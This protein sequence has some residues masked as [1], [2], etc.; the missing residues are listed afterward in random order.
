MLN[1]ITSLLQRYRSI[2][3]ST[4]YLIFGIFL[5]NLVN[6]AFILILN[7]YLRKHGFVD[8]QIGN[9]T[10]Y[11]FLGVLALAF[12]FG[13]YIKGKSLKP[14]FIAA[15]LIIPLTGLLMI[16]AVRWNNILL[17]K[18]SFLTWGIGLMMLQVC[19][20]PFIMRTTPKSIV[21]EAI[22][23]NFSMWSLAIIVTG[24]IIALANQIPAFTLFHLTINWSEHQLLFMFILLSS[25]SILVMNKIEE[26]KPRSISSKFKNNFSRILLDYDWSLLLKPLI[27]TLLIAV[28]AGLTIPFINLFF[29]SVFGLDSAQFGFLGSIASLLGFFALIL[30]PSIKR[31][32]GYKIAIIFSQSIAIALLVILILTELYSSVQGILYIAV[33][34]YLLRQPLMHMAAPITSEL[35]LKYVGEKNQE[36]I[37][38]FNSS[39]WSASWFISAKIFQYLRS[40]DF[41]YYKIFI[42]TAILYTIGVILYY[43]IIQDYQNRKQLKRSTTSFEPVV[44]ED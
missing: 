1:S 7:I 14:F 17:I 41:P 18:L 3:K 39:I 21:P 9:F 37:S 32:Y 30:A 16:E 2:P 5:L 6:G 43:Y 12:P 44:L 10:S 33:I 31:R 40:L 38:A 27:P 36:L 15:A 26:S 23:L 29:Y 42:F 25:F 8:Q 35:T 4:L 20:L 24:Q 22:T 11:R 19:A 13:I 34:S 28:G